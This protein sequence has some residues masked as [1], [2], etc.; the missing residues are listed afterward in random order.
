IPHA[1]DNFVKFAAEPV[2]ASHFIT[3]ACAS[4]I[5]IPLWPH[6]ILPATLWVYEKLTGD[7]RM[8]WRDGSK[9]PSE[10]RLDGGGQKFVT[11]SSE[12][13]KKSVDRVDDL[14]SIIVVGIDVLD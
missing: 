9:E 14:V 1:R 3:L 6:A 12:V 8:K 11:G 7:K 4:A 2:I 13:L 10:S 5:N